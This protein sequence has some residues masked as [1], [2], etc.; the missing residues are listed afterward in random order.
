MSF[1]TVSRR[2][3]PPLAR[4][5]PLSRFA[6][7]VGGGSAFYVRRPMRIALFI[8]LFVA[9]VAFA[10]QASR[11]AGLSN[12]IRGYVTYGWPQ[13]WLHADVVNIDIMGKNYDKTGTAWA[14]EWRGF[15]VSVGIGGCIAALLSAPLFLSPFK[16]YVRIWAGVVLAVIVCI[17]VYCASLP[18]LAPPHGWSPPDGGWQVWVR[19]R[20]PFFLASPGWFTSGMHWSLAE[21]AARWGAVVVI[22]G[23]IFGFKRLRHHDKPAA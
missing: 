6:P 7:R 4:S 19:T 20:H 16:K 11:Q 12:G 18:L 9:V 10:T 17:V 22:A 15:S 1:H 23:L 14:V 5:V 13:P 2:S 8:L 21:T 3:Q